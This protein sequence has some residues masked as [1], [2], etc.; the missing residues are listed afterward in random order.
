MWLLMFSS[1]LDLGYIL[2]PEIARDV[3]ETVV[4]NTYGP[5]T[6]NNTSPYF[7]GATHISHLLKDP[8]TLSDIAPEYQ[9]KALEESP[10]LAQSVSS[11]QCLSSRKRQRLS[12]KGKKHP[13]LEDVR[14]IIREKF[15]ASTPRERFHKVYPGE[16]RACPYS[17]RQM[18]ASNEPLTDFQQAA[19]DARQMGWLLEA[20][21]HL[22]LCQELYWN[23]LV[24]PSLWHWRY[25]QSLIRG[26]KTTDQMNRCHHLDDFIWEVLKLFKGSFLIDYL[27]TE[28]TIRERAYEAEF[29]R[30][31]QVFAGEC[32][33]TPQAMTPLGDGYVDFIVKSKKWLIELVRDGD[34]IP[35][36]L[37]RID[38]DGK[39]TRAWPDHDS[40]VVDFRFTNTR[41]NDSE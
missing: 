7:N 2:V 34:H 38:D 31:A 36:H 24:L 40:R 15:I 32:V 12:L 37:R 16:T 11:E 13:E 18:V 33:L 39:Y 19:H 17:A 9:S 14:G 3:P 5:L 28:H 1:V 4:C 30:C 21:A 25:L 8:V 20:P 35:D 26:G 29:Y 10:L 27:A 41:R 22:N 6:T 23:A